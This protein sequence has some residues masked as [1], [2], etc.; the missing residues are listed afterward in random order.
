MEI[1]I[2]KGMRD[3]SGEDSI[4]R[5]KIKEVLVKYFSLYGFEPAETPIIESEK[6]VKGDNLQ[7]EAVSDTA[8][9]L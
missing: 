2:A 9:V 7:D 8:R 3:F 4:K 6:F 5:Q 1:Q